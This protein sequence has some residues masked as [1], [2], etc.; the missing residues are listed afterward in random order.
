MS[1]RTDPVESMWAHAWEMLSQAER[2]HRQF[3]RLA[4]SPRGQAVWEPPAD[5]FEDGREVVIVVA[6]PGVPAESVE[7]IVDAGTLTVRGERPF[8]ANASGC[9]VRQLELPYGYFERRLALPPG[10]FTLDSHE[11]SH[12]CLV[13]RFR[14]HG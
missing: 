11:L 14:K 5:V 10:S 3:F 4:S 13:L 12:G 7:V 1:R 2:M 8:P 6:M 9:A